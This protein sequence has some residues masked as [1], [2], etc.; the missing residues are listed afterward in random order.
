MGNPN[1]TWPILLKTKMANYY[2]VNVNDWNVV[3]TWDLKKI[4]DERVE[5]YWT[6][7]Y[8]EDL[9]KYELDKKTISKAQKDVTELSIW[10][11]PDTILEKE[12]VVI[13]EN[14]APIEDKPMILTRKK[15]KKAKEEPADIN[16]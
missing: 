12:T 8:W 9:P 13:D 14:D 10:E 16:F 4:L 15:V 1:Y 7:F 5:S 11:I 2:S 6:I 3:E